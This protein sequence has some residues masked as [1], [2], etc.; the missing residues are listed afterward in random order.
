MTPESYELSPLSHV[1]S[2]RQEKRQRFII[3]HDSWFKATWDWFVLMLVMYTAVEIPYGAS[4]FHVKER[5]SQQ[6]VWDR[7][8]A[9]QAVE[10][11][12]LMVDLMF[13]VDILINF[14]T[15]YVDEATDNIVSIPKKIAKNYIKSWFIVDSLA[16]IPFEYFISSQAEEVRNES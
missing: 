12:N 8:Y 15:T 4:S 1:V 7:I 3:S 6:T 13:L 10:L 16:A 11:C 9:A 14:R 2:P 5:D